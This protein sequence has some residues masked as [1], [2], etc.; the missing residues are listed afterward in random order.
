M[1]L[2][3]DGGTS[4]G[5][6]GDTAESAQAPKALGLERRPA[7][8]VRKLVREQLRTV[9]R[10]RPIG[11]GAA[12]VRKVREATL[13]AVQK[14][15]SFNVAVKWLLSWTNPRLTLRSVWYGP[16]SGKD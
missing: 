13:R 3:R 2:K 11:M 14:D 15:P 7:E 16:E 1:R 6:G 12:T 4:T 5:S 8:E 9:D 10:S